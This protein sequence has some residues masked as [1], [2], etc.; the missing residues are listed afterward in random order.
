MVK[1]EKTIRQLNIHTFLLNYYSLSLE[2]ILAN[3]PAVHSI[4]I[5]IFFFFFLFY[6]FVLFFRL[7]NVFF[8]F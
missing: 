4:K 2:I 1:L 7:Y 6:L 8:F 3:L 5:F